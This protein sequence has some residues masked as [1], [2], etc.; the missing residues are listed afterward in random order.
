MVKETLSEAEH[1]RARA[2]REEL[3]R[4]GRW[5]QSISIPKPKK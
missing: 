4:T 5:G 3:V 2:Y 1:I